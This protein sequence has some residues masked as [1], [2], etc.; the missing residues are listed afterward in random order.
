LDENRIF[1]VEFFVALL[2]ALVICDVFIVAF[3]IVC[4]ARNTNRLAQL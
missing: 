3:F 1:A 2:A 4:G